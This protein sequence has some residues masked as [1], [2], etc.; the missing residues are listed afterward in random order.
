[1]NQ[2]PVRMAVCGLLGGLKP[3]D[4]GRFAQRVNQSQAKVSG[5]GRLDYEDNDPADVSGLSKSSQ[6]TA[7]A[8]AAASHRPAA[9]QVCV[10]SCSP[11]VV[12]ELDV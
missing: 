3:L 4:G 10:I 2:T 8:R 11:L 6:R 5:R 1:M 7:L 12:L 9:W